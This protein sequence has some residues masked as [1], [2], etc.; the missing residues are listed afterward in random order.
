MSSVNKTN[1]WKYLIKLGKRSI[2]NDT[3]NNTRGYS[4]F[5]A[6]GGDEKIGGGREISEILMG[7]S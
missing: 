3:W 1:F 2:V 7:K 6:W 5:T 4:L